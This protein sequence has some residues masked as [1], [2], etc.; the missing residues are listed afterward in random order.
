MIFRKISAVKIPEKFQVAASG[1]RKLQH[2]WTVFL[3]VAYRQQESHRPKLQHICIG[4]TSAQVY[5]LDDPGL[6][7]DIST[8]ETV[9]IIKVIAIY[10]CNG[11]K[12][13]SRQCFEVTVYL[14]VEYLKNG[15]CVCLLHALN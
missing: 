4:N 10:G 13:T 6:P 14:Q 12:R 1:F 15:A 11:H 7:R 3:C 2:S 5:I 8:R 9:K